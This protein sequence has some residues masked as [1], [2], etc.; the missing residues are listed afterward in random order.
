MNFP[1]LFSFT[2]RIT[3]GPLW[4]LMLAAIVLAVIVNLLVY[5]VLGG[6]VDENGNPRVS[7]IALLVY[8]CLYLVLGI[9][10]ISFQIRR[11]HDRDRSGWF[12]LLWLLPILNIWGLIEMYFLA[13]TPGTN[14][15]GADPLRRDLATTAEA[16][17]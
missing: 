8:A 7:P 10:G 9:I 12:V 11:C 16:F 2:G 13:G 17:R 15:F 1:P 14:R 5:F 3:R 6:M 4:L